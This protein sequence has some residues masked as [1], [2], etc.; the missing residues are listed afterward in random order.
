MGCYG[1]T[2]WY[3]HRSCCCDGKGEEKYFVFLR[4]SVFSFDSWTVTFCKE[5]TWYIELNHGVITGWLEAQI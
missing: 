3:K 2:P 5:E 4:A 1:T